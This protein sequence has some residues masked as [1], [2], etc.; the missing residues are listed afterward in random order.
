MATIEGTARALPCSEHRRHGGARKST[1]KIDMGGGGSGC[2]MLH[3]AHEAWLVFGDRQRHGGKGNPR[4]RVPLALSTSRRR[5]CFSFRHSRGSDSSHV[6]RPSRLVQH[7]LQACAQLPLPLPGDGVKP[8]PHAQ[9]HRTQYW[10]PRYEDS[11]V[12]SSPHARP[13][14]RLGAETRQFRPC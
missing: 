13:E 6:F 2:S 11:S 8:L 3:V 1:M 14:R 7:T 4:K 10:P 5:L 9:K 12:V